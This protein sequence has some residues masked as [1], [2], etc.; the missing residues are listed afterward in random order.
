MPEDCTT[1]PLA[2]KQQ[3]YRPA[4]KVHPALW[5]LSP[6]AR[7]R[8]CQ[9]LAL[10]LAPGPDPLP[11]ADCAACL[12]TYGHAVS[13]ATQQ[14]HTY[15]TAY[16]RVARLPQA[17]LEA[18]NSAYAAAADT[19]DPLSHTHAA[20][21]YLSVAAKA[22]RTQWTQF[23]PL[24]I[25][26]GLVAL[27]VTA[28]VATS[29]YAMA[30]QYR[31]RL[32][33]ST[34]AVSRAFFL[35]PPIHAPSGL[36]L[37]PPVAAIAALVAMR[38]AI[39]FSNSLI[40]GE[41]QVTTFLIATGITIAA[42]AAISRVLAVHDVVANK[43]YT[44][45][46]LSSPPT[47]LLATLLLAVSA[48]QSAGQMVR[49]EPLATE[50]DTSVVEPDAVAFHGKRFRK[51]PTAVAFTLLIFALLLP[52]FPLRL[53]AVVMFGGALFALVRMHWVFVDPCRKGSAT[54]S[55]QKTSLQ[56]TSLA[57]LQLAA[58][59]VIALWS[60]YALDHYGGID[61]IGANPFDK[62]DATAGSPPAPTTPTAPWAVAAPLLLIASLLAALL[63]RAARRIVSLPATVRKF[64]MHVPW[65]KALGDMLLYL[66]SC[67][68]LLA[69]FLPDRRML[70]ILLE[71][72]TL[73]DEWQ[74]EEAMHH[75]A[76]HEV[77]RCPLCRGSQCACHHLEVATQQYVQ[78]QG[79]VL[80]HRWR[81]GGCRLQLPPLCC[82]RQVGRLLCSQLWI[83]V[84]CAPC[85]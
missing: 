45:P 29:S 4:G 23:R 33:S 42:A 72:D 62:G 85:K 35:L 13:S 78:Q 2:I 31:N 84:C 75:H 46:T 83:F 38:A 19:L 11:F 36:A 56:R 8:P 22:A 71:L 70:L 30:L 12:A 51:L 20:L 39:P 18:L 81:C 68:G 27:A 80:H 7:G 40:L 58:Y 16:A 15:L 37:P 32:F 3:R 77:R 5:A 59:T 67:G 53:V 69:W 48:L 57:V 82:I 50:D 1:S 79:R 61:R 63:D 10:C 54:M 60:C 24:S 49:G 14:V 64:G 26:A 65:A 41:L 66:K 47:S 74:H 9:S 25:I 34:A 55:W 76:V 6:D 43:C 21:A 17:T 28:L 44:S 52:Y 73:D